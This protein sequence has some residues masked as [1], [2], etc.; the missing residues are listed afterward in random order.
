MFSWCILQVLYHVLGVAPAYQTFIGPAL[1]ELCLGLQ[2]DEVAPVWS[3]FFSTLRDCHLCLHANSIF[4]Y[5]LTGSMRYLCERY[6]CKNGLPKCCQVHSFCFQL[7]DTWECGDC[8]Q[9]LACF[10]WYRKGIIFTGFLYPIVQR[11]IFSSFYIICLRSVMFKSHKLWA[12]LMLEIASSLS[13]THYTQTRIPLFWT[14]F[15]Y[16]FKTTVWIITFEF[17]TVQTFTFDYNFNTKNNR[18]MKCSWTNWKQE[19]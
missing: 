9:H 11:A 7:F 19:L 5:F 10:A 3:Y 1:N 16:I 15:L 14:V 4:A 12:W 6:S 8:N 18:S 2:P 13:S 17:V